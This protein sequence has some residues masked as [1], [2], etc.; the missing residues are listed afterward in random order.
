MFV[1]PHHAPGHSQADFGEALV[2]IGGTEQKAHFFAF[3]LPHSDACYV[4]AYPAAT[5]EAW[6]DGHVHAFA[7]F[8]RVALSVLHDNDR[9]L[10]ARILPDGLRQRAGVFSGLLSHYLIHD[11]Y[12]RPVKAT[13]KPLSEES[14]AGRGATSWCRC[15]ALRPRRSST[16]GWRSNA[17]SAMRTPCA[18]TARRS[19]SG[20][21][22]TSG[23]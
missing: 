12:G 1:P 20:F 22:G 21:S 15:R 6:V 11:R 2:A 3:D 17:A 9:C 23:R 18:A 13:T 16:P 5:A 10:V 7:F 19:G 8:G 14:S 4:R